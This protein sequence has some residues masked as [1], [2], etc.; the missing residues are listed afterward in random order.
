MARI[1][2]VDD[3]Q[4]FREG[5]ASLIDDSEQDVLVASCS[6]GQDLIER[7]SSNEVDVVVI[8]LSLK[9]GMS[10]GLIAE[11]KRLFPDLKTIVIS[12]HNDPQ[13]VERAMQ[14]GADGYALKSDA[15]DDLMFAIRAAE[16][17]GRFISPTIIS[18][19]DVSISME[20]PSVDDMPLRQRQIL[21]QLAHG[22]S[23]KKIAAELEIALP[24]VKNHLSV[25]FKKYGVSNRVELLAKLRPFDHG[26]L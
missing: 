6:D 18:R 1:F 5:V 20:R 22:R 19:G 15:F 26:Q 3:H 7:V 17:G 2:L 23:N 12:M 11:L 9:E 10:F 24:T 25:L 16:R 14:A 4:I 21:E 8:D 13:I